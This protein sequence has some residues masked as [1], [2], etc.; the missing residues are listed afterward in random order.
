VT[1]QETAQDTGTPTA[2]IYTGRGAN[3][4]TGD[5]T[6]SIDEETRKRTNKDG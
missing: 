3:D 2:G 6:Q 1:V 4:S 5:Y